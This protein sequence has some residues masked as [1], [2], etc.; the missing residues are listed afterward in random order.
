MYHVPEDVY[1]GI[2]ETMYGGISQ[3]V[4]NKWIN[5]LFENKLLPEIEEKE[6]KHDR[7]KRNEY[8]AKATIYRLTEEGEP[9]F[10]EWLEKNKKKYPDDYKEY[11]AMKEEIKE[12]KKREKGKSKSQIKR[13]KKKEKTKGLEQEAETTV[14][15]IIEKI[16][17]IKHEVQPEDIMFEELVLQEEPKEITTKG[18]TSP[19]EKQQ[20]IEKGVLDLYGV[21]LR[22]DRQFDTRVIKELEGIHKQNERVNKKIEA[23][24]DN[25]PV[26]MDSELARLIRII[27]MK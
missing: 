19:R 20:L 24:I 10:R 27:E 4:R 7:E 18:R 16:E 12:E 11:V 14:E 22:Q 21:K 3:Q 2:L 23:I 17:E 6:Y 26:K 25:Y 13:A 1:N 8:S 15:D 9:V 5:Y